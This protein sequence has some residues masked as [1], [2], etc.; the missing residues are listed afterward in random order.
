[1]LGQPLPLLRPS[2]VAAIAD[3]HVTDRT[4]AHMMAVAGGC[5]DIGQC[6]EL[7]RKQRPHKRHPG[8]EEQ[9]R[10]QLISC[11]AVL[12]VCIE[13]SL[14]NCENDSTEFLR[15]VNSV[16]RAVLALVS[17]MGTRAVTESAF[18]CEIIAAREEKRT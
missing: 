7:L 5:W 14:R 12:H 10:G 17:A 6:A 18:E 13:T 2:E 3:L 16:C 4:Q 15:K 1:M 11:P 8:G 9:H